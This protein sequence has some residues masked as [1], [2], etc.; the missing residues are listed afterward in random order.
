MVFLTCIVIFIFL[1]NYYYCITQ[2]VGFM[3]AFVG[4][5][6]RLDST[7]QPFKLE[8]CPFL[9]IQWI[10]YWTS[11]SL[12]IVYCFV[13]QNC[14]NQIK[15]NYLTLMARKPKK[16]HRAYKEWAPSVRLH[17]KLYFSIFLPCWF[18]AQVGSA[19]AIIKSMGKNLVHRLQYQDWENRVHK[20][21]EL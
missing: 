1:I 15:S 14:T 20:M 6:H 9:C 7:V 10:S 8:N 2:L 5:F 12:F 11:F 21:N 4:R 3:S 19:Q 17:F 13:C 18:M 16:S